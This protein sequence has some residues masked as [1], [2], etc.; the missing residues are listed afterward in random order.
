MQARQDNHNTIAVAIADYTIAPDLLRLASALA[1]E[2]S[3][4]IVLLAIVEVPETRS[5]SEGARQAQKL[6]LKL[7]AIP[8]PLA[9]DLI[10]IKPVVRVSHQVPQGIVDAVAE[11]QVQTLILG[12]KGFTT[13]PDKTYSTTIDN[14]IKNPP[15]NIIVAK[16]ANL[17]ACRRILLPVRGG[18][19]AELALQVATRLAATLPATINVMHSIA[20]PITADEPFLAFQ[21][22][23]A[24]HP[25]I[26]R[27]T[28][29]RAEAEDAIL[30]EA[31][32]HDLVIMGATARLD[33]HPSSLGPI[34]EAVAKHIDK[35]LIIVKTR[36][37]VDL[38]AYTQ[39]NEPIA[40]RRAS[41][42]STK[43]STL[44]D[45]WFAEN[46]FHSREFR[47]VARL[48]ELKRKQRLTISL[49][50]PTLNEEKT[51]GRII[52]TMQTNLVDKHP[53]LDEIVIIDSGSTDNTA[54]IA[55]SLNVPVYRH[56]DILP[57]LGSFKGKGEAL[58]KS[59]HIL[60]GDIIAWIDTDIT[61]IHPAFVYGLLGPL[62]TEPRIKYVKGFYRRP[63]AL[64]D[65]LTATGGGRVTELTARPILNLFFPELSGVIQPLS[66]EYAG[67]REILERV[68]FFTGY[69]VETGLLIDIFDRFGLE[70][71]AQVDL[72]RRIHRNQSLL[73]LSQ[74]A[75]AIIQ[76]FIRRLEDRHCLTLLEEV[77]KSMKLI[78]DHRAGYHLELKEIG[79][80]ERPPIITIPQYRA[81]HH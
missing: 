79:D 50:L 6:R 2:Q 51:I 16:P 30:T 47:D 11:Q 9:S 46:T 75:F 24:D 13:T 22:L 28:T 8:A 59:L 62:L 32:N 34:C 44:V 76:V 25:A 39:P 56:Q 53:L 10:D 71:I 21:R 26:H 37:P 40:I 31:A 65:K 80:H 73:A 19:Y 35:S 81:L 69:G 67:R 60:K 77:N 48:V 43:L 1:P 66:G 20:D 33:Q 74:M 68:P 12:W 63:L 70:S 3:A 36:E 64:G 7:S 17:S 54:N 52:T 18:Q 58:W 14:I 29:I 41:L 23:I 15:C 55:A 38:S 72:L 5:L 49:G 45:K 42:S 27:I 57:E 4:R 61:N 78:R